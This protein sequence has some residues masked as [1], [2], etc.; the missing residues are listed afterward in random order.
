[1]DAKYF[2]ENLREKPLGRPRHRWD[3]SGLDSSGE[4]KCGC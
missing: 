1:M 4:H 3:Y 2:P